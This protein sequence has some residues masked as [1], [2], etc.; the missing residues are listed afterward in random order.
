MPLPFVPMYTLRYYVSPFSHREMNMLSSLPPVYARITRQ[1]S[2]ARRAEAMSRVIDLNPVCARIVRAEVANATNVRR[3]KEGRIS[4]GLQEHHALPVRMT[5]ISYGS[6]GPESDRPGL[7]N[8]TNG[9]ER[10]T[11]VC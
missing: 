4:T 3:G 9:S 11:V 1:D 10:C 2:A 5:W 8:A 6:R 7:C